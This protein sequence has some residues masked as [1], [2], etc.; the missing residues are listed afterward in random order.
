MKSLPIVTFSEP[1]TD[2]ECLVI[3]R[4]DSGRVALALSRKSDG[5]VEVL[6]PI[7]VAKEF[8]AHLVRALSIAAGEV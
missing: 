6:M 5:D 8:Q 3:L 2:E 7:S 1:H 4:A